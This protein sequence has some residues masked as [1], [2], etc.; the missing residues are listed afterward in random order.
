M[1]LDV[2]ARTSLRLTFGVIKSVWK[3]SA[4]NKYA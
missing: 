3:T 1:K 4:C 2:L